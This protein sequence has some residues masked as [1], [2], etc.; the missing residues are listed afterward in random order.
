MQREKIGGGEKRK[1]TQKPTN[2]YMLF[3]QEIKKDK[4]KK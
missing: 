2:G 4:E 1:K 3:F